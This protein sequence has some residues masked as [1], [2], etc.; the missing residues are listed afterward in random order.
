[1]KTLNPSNRCFC[2]KTVIGI[3]ASI[4]AIGSLTACGTPSSPPTPAEKSTQNALPSPAQPAPN[5]NGPTAT[6]PNAAPNTTTAP[7]ATAGEAT[8]QLFWLKDTGSKFELMPTPT[9]IS[10]ASSEPKIILKAAFEKLL[11]PPSDPKLINT[12]PAGTKLLGVD[13]KSDG[14]HVDFS[15]EFA[16]GGGSATL[17]GR[18]AQVIYTATSL[19]PQAPVWISVGGKPLT[20]IGGEGL[21]VSQP[22]DRQKFDREFSW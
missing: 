7:K 22:I 13:V 20:S 6:A 5:I 11:T 14:V 16:S 8:A 15:P 10:A 12:I 2:Q 19:D 9:K 21:E 3:L 1:M 4:L 18:L 17:S